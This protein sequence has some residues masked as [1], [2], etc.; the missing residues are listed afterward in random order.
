M[1]GHGAYGVVCSARN[2]KT[3]Q[4]VAIKKVI[5]SHKELKCAV[6]VGYEHKIP[7]FFDFLTKRFH[8]T[9]SWIGYQCL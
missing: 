5:E 6:Y 1:I 4:K 9:Y 3:G 8:P 2:K 7:L